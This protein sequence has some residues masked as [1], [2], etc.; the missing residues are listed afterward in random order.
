MMHYNTDRWM[1]RLYHESLRET[2]LLRCG[3]DKLEAVRSKKRKRFAEVLGLSVIQSK[4]FTPVFEMYQSEKKEGY[5]LISGH[6][7]ILPELTVPLY[8]LEPV[9]SADSAVRD[10]VIIYSHGHGLGATEAIDPIHEDKYQKCLPVHLAQKGYKV[11]V[12]ELI[13]FGRVRMESFLEEE[14]SGC[15][16]NATQL[17]MNGITMAGLRVYQILA[18]IEHIQ[19]RTALKPVLAGISGGGLVTA[20]TAALGC[21]I[22][23]AFISCFTNTFKGSIMSMFHCV[24]NFIPNILSVGEEPE[25]IAMACPTPLLISAGRE[26]PIFPIT[27]TEEAVDM[28]QN[29]YTRFGTTG[30]IDVEIFDGVHEISEGALYPWL[31]KI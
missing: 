23:G 17:L 4:A 11:F 29:I 3:Q 21:D 7:T 30:K 19:K 24:D 22:K 18:L 25:I 1:E 2:E 9:A 27:H 16:A 31:R 20:F 26:D 12:P 13:G 15:Y 6:Y 5:T 8:I 28:I 14:Y 10:E